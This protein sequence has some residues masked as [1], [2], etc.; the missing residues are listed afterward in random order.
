MLLKR[1]L[2]SLAA[3]V[4]AGAACADESAKPALN[5]DVT[6]ATIA[7][8]ICTKG[9]TRTV[10]PYVAEMKRIKADMLAA[11]GEPIDH[12]NRYE[13]DHVVPLAL[14]GTV[15]DRRNLALQPIDEARQK[16]A[17][18]V[19]LSSL[20]CQGKIALDDAQSAIWEDWRKA[21]VLCEE[22]W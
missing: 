22:K 9:W 17:V 7:E 3:V 13:L 20:V 21:G 12:R 18:E 6:Q 19:C 5:P 15:I 16:D 14:G 8:T 1:L 4:V 10:R 11:I 2:F